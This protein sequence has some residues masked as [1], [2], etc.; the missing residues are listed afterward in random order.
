MARFANDIPKQKTVGTRQPEMFYNSRYALRIVALNISGDIAVI[1][2]EK[3]NYYKLPGD[4]INKDEDH[5]SAAQREVE[6]ETGATVSLRGTGCRATTEEFR[7]DLHQ[8]SYCAGFGLQDLGI[9][10]QM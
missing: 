5:H 3:G 6:E 1:Y 4:G 10:S 7:N 9:G 2:A 8:I